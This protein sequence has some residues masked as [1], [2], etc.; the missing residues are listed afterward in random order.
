IQSFLGS[1]QM[2]YHIGWIYRLAVLSI[3]HCCRRPLHFQINLLLNSAGI[4]RLRILRSGTFCV[5]FQY[6]LRISFPYSSEHVLIVLMI[7]SPFIM[8]AVCEIFCGKDKRIGSGLWIGILAFP[9]SVVTIT[10]SIIVISIVIEINWRGKRERRKQLLL[11]SPCAGN[12]ITRT[13]FG[14]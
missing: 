1:I 11:D 5:S 7:I 3:T 12:I 8:I 4:L 10:I 2:N 14:F 9:I 6:V 13:L